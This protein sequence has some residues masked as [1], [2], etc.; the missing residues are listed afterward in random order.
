MI[1]SLKGVLEIDGNKVHHTNHIEEGYHQPDEPI[2]IRHPQDTIEVKMMTS[3]ASEGGKGCQVTVFIHMA[4]FI[5]KFLNEKF[6]CEE[7]KMTIHHL[8]C[9]LFNQKRRTKNRESRGVEG[10]NE[11]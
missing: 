11:L 10:K 3:T 9:A 1:G 4:L 2:W 6:P 5:L 7:N 8:E